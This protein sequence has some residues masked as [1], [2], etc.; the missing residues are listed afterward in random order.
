[1]LLGGVNFEVE[2]GRS[3]RAA[4]RG[5]DF[6]RGMAGRRFRSA[7]LG[8][9]VCV[10]MGATAARGDSDHDRE[11]EVKAA[12]V[13]NFAKYVDWPASSFDRADSPFVLGIAGSDPFG[14]IIDRAVQGKSVNGHAFVVK[15]M[16]WGAEMRACHIMFV[17]AS[18]RERVPQL[19]GVLQGAAVLT[20]GETPGF[21]SHGGVAGFFVEQG[22]V[23]FE[24]NPD[25]AR[26]AHLV[27]SSRLLA[28]ARIV[29]DS[30]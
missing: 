30:K 13:F 10:A 5:D 24:I 28:L 9:L 18:E 27:I 3:Q 26:R 20:I 22:R 15:R 4:G 11:Y 16:H 29:S 17:S 1:M 21:A 2:F 8:A 7:L 25:A 14:S 12:F 23:R 6:R 19:P